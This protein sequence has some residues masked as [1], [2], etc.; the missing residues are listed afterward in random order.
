[1]CEQSENGTSFLCLLAPWVAF[2]LLRMVYPLSILLHLCKFPQA[3][4]LLT[5]TIVSSFLFS[6]TNIPLTN[7]PRLCAAFYLEYAEYIVELELEL[8]LPLKRLRIQI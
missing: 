5:C 7:I 2:H 8:E 6:H 4:I 1:M 3:F